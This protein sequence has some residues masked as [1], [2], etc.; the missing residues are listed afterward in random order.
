MDLS[1]L[2]KE[3]ELISGPVAA[4]FVER[5]QTELDERQARVH[6][7]HEVLASASA[8]KLGEA[9]ERLA[10]IPLEPLSAEIASALDAVRQKAISRQAE[11]VAPVAAVLAGISGEDAE[12]AA[13]A[14]LEDAVAEGFGKSLGALLSKQHRR[15]PN[16]PT[17]AL[18]L[19]RAHCLEGDWAE[20]E[21]V[22]GVAASLRSDPASRVATEF[23]GIFLAFEEEQNKRAL[24]WVE[25]MLDVPWHHVLL[26]HIE[27]LV[28]ESVVPDSARGPLSVLL[29]GTGSPFYTGLV[30]RL[31]V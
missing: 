23:E 18:W 28:E 5:T 7:R 17:R 19:A 27:G 12:D 30:G 29:E 15:S 3:L 26:P 1:E 9:A 6:A 2:K 13:F 14:A 25:R 20:G 22:Y 8:G 16:D 11:L 10:R 24:R 21:R 31:R 4:V